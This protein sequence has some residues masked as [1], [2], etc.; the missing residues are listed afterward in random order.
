MAEASSDLDLRT[1]TSAEPVARYRTWFEDR[2]GGAPLHVSVGLEQLDS[3]LARRHEPEWWTFGFPAAQVLRYAWATDEARRTLGPDPSFTIAAGEPELEDFVEYLGKVQR[4][5][6]RGDVLGARLF[7][8]AVGLL[9]PRLVRAPDDEVV[10]HDRREALTAA[11]ALRVTPEH[12]GADLPV[13]LG[14]VEAG[15]P[16][17]ID[18]ALRLGR[19]LLAFLREHHPDV[20]AQPDIARYL[21]DGTLERHLGFL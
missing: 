19:E 21:A 4:C 5:A 13:V 3:W 8:Q 2:P 7:A 11:L 10:V 14:L 6:R 15:D 17:V 12:Y 18:A 20:D 9:A 16:A 1:L